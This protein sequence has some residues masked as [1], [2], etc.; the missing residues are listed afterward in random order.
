MSDRK[1]GNGNQPPTRQQC[2]EAYNHL[3]VLQMVLQMPGEEIT[4]DAR[5]GMMQMLEGVQGL[6]GGLAH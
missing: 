5:A 4:D 6:I 1:Q 3:A 2:K